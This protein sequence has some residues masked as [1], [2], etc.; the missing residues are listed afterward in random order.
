MCGPPPPSQPTP[1]RPPACTCLTAAADDPFT[2]GVIQNLLQRHKE[3]DSA[4]LARAAFDPH[5][6][7]EE[8]LDAGDLGMEDSDVHD[9]TD[10]IIERRLREVGARRLVAVWGSATGWLGGLAWAGRWHAAGFSNFQGC[11]AAQQRGSF[12]AA[13]A[14]GMLPPPDCSWPPSA[15]PPLPCSCSPPSTPA[16]T[17]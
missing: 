7:H 4:H 3:V 2:V 13:P 11:M 6:A 17:A 16:T 1:C 5:Y 10:D 8:D 15:S 12:S 14:K 9:P